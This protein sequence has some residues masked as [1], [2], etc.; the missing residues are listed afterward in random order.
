MAAILERSLWEF[1]EAAALRYKTLIHQALR[2]IG[3]DPERI[4]S[5][6]RPALAPGARTY[7][8]RLSR[9]RVAGGRVKEPRHLLLYRRRENDVKIARIL[10][11]AQDLK[12]H[13]SESDWSH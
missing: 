11:D 12:K 8:L 4:G 9:H 13:L 3:A 7:H 1:G 10:H 2:D 6:S 5:I